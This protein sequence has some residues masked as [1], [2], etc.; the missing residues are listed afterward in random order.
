MESKN[1]HSKAKKTKP[2]YSFARG[3]AAFLQLFLFPIKYHGLE[4]IKGLEPPFILIANHLSWYD[5]LSIAVPF[6]KFPVHF[7]GKKELVD[8]SKLMARIFDAVYMIPIARKEADIGA[9]KK[10]L[11]TLKQNEVLGIF[12][13][14]TRY[15]GGDMQNPES[16]VSLIAFMSKVPVIPAYIDRAFK[17][18]QKVN[19]YFM[20]P[21]E[22]MDL[23]E[24]TSDGNAN[25]IFMERLKE[26]YRNIVKMH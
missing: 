19:V 9:I 24:N 23:L 14:G 1:N 22:Y 15:R 2:L 4:K 16:G 18:F 21:I 26:S 5:P 6:K 11:K 12:P 20:D 7:L 3:L 10:A 13:E 17:P 25:E 8:K